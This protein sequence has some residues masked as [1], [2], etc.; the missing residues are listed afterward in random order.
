MQRHC[1]VLAVVRF[2]GAFAFPKGVSHSERLNGVASNQPQ[3]GGGIC[4]GPDRIGW[5]VQRRRL[6]R[7]PACDAYRRFTHSRPGSGR[8]R[9]STRIRMLDAIAVVAADRQHAGGAVDVQ[10]VEQ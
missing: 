10:L 4:S 5:C 2:P 1:G 8:Q 6:G 9:V 3:R 7:P